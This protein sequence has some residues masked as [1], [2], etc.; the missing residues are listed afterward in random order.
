MQLLIVGVAYLLGLLAASEQIAAPAGPAVIVEFALKREMPKPNAGG[1]AA[2]GPTQL[3]SAEEIRTLPRRV[4]RQGIGV[5]VL[6][7]RVHDMGPADA[8]LLKWAEEVDTALA[9]LA[10]KVRVV[11]WIESGVGTAATPVLAIKDLYF[12]PQGNLG[13]MTPHDEQLHV[14][15]RDLSRWIAPAERMAARVGRAALIHRAMFEQVPVSADGEGK[16]LKFRA[17]AEGQHVLNLPGEILTLDAHRA[18]RFGVA[19]GIVG[20]TEELR[21]VLGVAWVELDIE[22]N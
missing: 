16:D 1:E 7:V 19:R 17:G 22:G 5:V 11:A 8:E 6:R 18:V 20:S 21:K 15:R 2:Q 3:P 9:A 10:E 14:V 4:A 13:A 12:A